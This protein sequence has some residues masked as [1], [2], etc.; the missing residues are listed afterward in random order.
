LITKVIGTI[1]T[2]RAAWGGSQSN[3]PNIRA[4]MNQA[5]NNSIQ[6]INI[7]F[8]RMSYLS[9]PNGHMSP[10]G[11][12]WFASFMAYI[13]HLGS[14]SGYSSFVSLPLTSNCGRH[15]G[16]HDHGTRI[17]LRASV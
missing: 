13:Y 11:L 10:Y 16:G 12:R 4:K 6:A 7:S 14:S 3:A 2:I 5:M 17:I 15:I 8:T 9:I 1:Y